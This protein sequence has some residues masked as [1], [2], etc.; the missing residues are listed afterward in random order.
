[1]RKIIPSLLCGLLS[2]GF[3]ACSSD[4]GEDFPSPERTIAATFRLQQ[5]G[6][7]VTINNDATNYVEDKVETVQLAGAMTG[8]YGGVANPTFSILSFQGKRNFLFTANLNNADL[9]KIATEKDYNEA[10]LSTADYMRGYQSIPTN[11]P[12][13]MAGALRSVS[14]VNGVLNQDLVILRRVFASVDYDFSTLLAGLQVEQII[15]KNIP[16]KFRLA[17]ALVDYDLLHAQ[18]STDYPY[19]DWN[20][21]TTTKGR[22]YLP[23][24][25]VS[26]PVFNDPDVN[27]MTHFEI[28]YRL[29]SGDSKII[30]FRLAE[31]RP[32]NINYGRIVRNTRYSLTPQVI[33]PVV[34][35]WGN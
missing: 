10:I 23:E 12:L 6:S 19:I 29:G 25:I 27:G 18:N 30:R 20:L 7:G 34:G 5:S 26:K 3:V 31:T 21:S 8:N 2:V 32:L 28:T 11:K 33:T 24:H 35:N 16:A 1:M 13:L 9:S 4:D 15:L 14:F 22:I 17:G